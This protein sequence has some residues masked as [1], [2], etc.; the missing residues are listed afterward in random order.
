[1][2]SL[3]CCK[4]QCSSCNATYG[5]IK[6]HFKVRASEPMGVSACTDKNIKS[7]INSAVCDH[8]LACDNTVSF[9]DISG[10]ANGTSDFTIKLQESLLIH[11]DGPELNRTSG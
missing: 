11:R 9:E 4:S 1:M 5:K 2:R 6:H 7:T 8:M 10:L 3:R